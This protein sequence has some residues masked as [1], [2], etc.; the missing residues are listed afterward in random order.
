MTECYWH[1]ERHKDQWSRTESIEIN[2]KIYNHLIWTSIPRQRLNFQYTRKRTLFNYMFLGQLTST[3]KIMK[4]GPYLTSY[5][6]VIQCIKNL[7]ARAKN[8]NLLK[9]NTE[10]ILLDLRLSN[11]FLDMTAKHWQQG[12]H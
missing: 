6:K 2:P 5:T 3:C 11:S 4:L 10:A 9:E 8:I 7:N 12:K 1:K